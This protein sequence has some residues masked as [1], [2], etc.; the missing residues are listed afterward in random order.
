MST[1]NNV[2]SLRYHLYLIIARTGTQN[3]WI[4]LRIRRLPLVYFGRS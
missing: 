2:K 3:A 4:V 1:T